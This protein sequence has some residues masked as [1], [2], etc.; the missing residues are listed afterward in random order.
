M[1]LATEPRLTDPDGFY[2]ALMEA[3]RGLDDASSRRLDAALVLLL[4]NQIGDA[5]V[6]LEAIRLA[7][8]AVAPAQAAPGARG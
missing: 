7:R 2:A 3:H 4:A 5:A 8:E 6:L 1:T